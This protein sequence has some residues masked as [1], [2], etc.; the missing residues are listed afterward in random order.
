MATMMTEMTVTKDRVEVTRR[1]NR[2]AIQSAARRSANLKTAASRSQAV[3][4][5]ALD[6]LR[7]AGYKP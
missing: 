6:A 4:R 7:R 2:A 3:R 1:R 5:A